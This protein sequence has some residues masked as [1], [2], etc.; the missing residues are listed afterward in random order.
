[1]HNEE[2]IGGSTAWARKAEVATSCH[3]GD[4]ECQ[5]ERWSDS[6]IRCRGGRCCGRYRMGTHQ[7]LLE[8]ET[9][10]RLGRGLFKHPEGKAYIL[11]RHLREYCAEALDAAQHAHRSV[12]AFTKVERRKSDG[13]HSQSCG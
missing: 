1:M 8:L 7:A 11:E 2:A 4:L 3:T 13:I 9:G 10:S 6:S 12:P 5:R